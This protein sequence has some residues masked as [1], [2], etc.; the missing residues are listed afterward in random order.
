MPTRLKLLL[1]VLLV[2]IIVAHVGMWRDPDMTFEVKQNW[3]LVNTL[4]WAVIVLPMFAVNQWLKVK[5]RKD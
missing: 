1:A 4:A 5:T 3:T 2:L